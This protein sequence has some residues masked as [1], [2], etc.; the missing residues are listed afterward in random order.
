MPTEPS[1]T[2]AVWCPEPSAEI[3]RR[4]LMP[5]LEHVTWRDPTV[6]PSRLAISSRLIPSATRSLIFSIACGVNFTRLP[7]TDGLAF[8]IVMAAPS[9][10]AQSSFGIDVR[11]TGTRISNRYSL[12]RSLNDTHDHRLTLDNPPN[13]GVAR[14]ACFI[15]SRAFIIPSRGE[16][17]HALR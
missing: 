7:L 12:N 13:S 10:V 11:F 3:I 6:T 2:S 5:N 8:V 4:K 15:D 14:L 17:V 16:H 1:L 9:R